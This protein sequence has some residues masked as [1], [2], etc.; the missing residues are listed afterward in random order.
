MAQKS[1]DELPKNDDKFW[2]DAEV[3]VIP[4]HTPRTCSQG[5]HNFIRIGH[6]AKCACGVGYALGPGI[7]VD[8]GHI[9]N[10]GTLLI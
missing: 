8:R 6:E 9:Y 5:K 1:V 3:E 7:I 10:L 4:P 2:K